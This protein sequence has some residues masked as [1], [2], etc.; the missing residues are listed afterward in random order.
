MRLHVRRESV[1]DLPADREPQELSMRGDRT[2]TNQGHDTTSR[3]T[4]PHRSCSRSLG[5]GRASPT[6][7]RAATADADEGRPDRAFRQDR[8][9]E[10]GPEQRRR[11]PRGSLREH[12]EAGLTSQEPER[13]G[14]VG[15]RQL[16]FGDDDRRRGI[17]QR[18]QRPAPGARTGGG[19]ATRRRAPAAVPAI[20]ET[21]RDAEGVV[22]GPR[23]WSGPSASRSRSAYDTAARR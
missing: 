4:S 16:G 17:D 5:G 2:A 15:R 13:Q 12:P 23:T 21:S 9:V 14:R 11:Q 8:E 19:P 22:A 20:A 18:G 1:Q 10:E 6:T 3:L 7:R